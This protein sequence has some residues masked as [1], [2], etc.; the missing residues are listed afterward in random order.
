MTS[1]TTAQFRRLFAELPAEVQRQARRAYRVFRQNPNHPSLRF[2]PIHPRR[3]IYSVRVSPGY[4]AVGILESDE[5]IWYW[6]GS[7][8]DYDRLLSQWRRRP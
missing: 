1:H 2:K 3:S 4:R 5:I 7:H 6:I 8:A